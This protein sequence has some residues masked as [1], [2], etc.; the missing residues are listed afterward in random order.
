MSFAMTAGIVNIYAMFARIPEMIV[1][2]VGHPSRQGNAGYGKRT[3]DFFPRGSIIGEP[4][5]AEDYMKNKLGMDPSAVDPMLKGDQYLDFLINQLRP[6]LAKKYRMS[7]DHTL[8][9]H[10]AGGAFTG[11]ALFAQPGG[12]NR[13][14]LGSGTNGL[15]LDLEDK[16]AK[17]H[18]DLDAKVFMGAGDLEVNNAGL[19]SLR[20]ISRTVILGE[21]LRLREYPSLSLQVKIYTDRDHVNVMPLVISDGLESVFAEESAK[22][23]HSVPW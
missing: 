23:R 7:D 12:F 1:V 22:I 13:Y 4:G 21:T 3:I 15:T 18:K 2:G 19:S 6:A 8:W 9:G 10:S 11:Y 14:I 17:V 20:F 5:P 16:Y